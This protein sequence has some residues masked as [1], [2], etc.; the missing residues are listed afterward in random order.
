MIEELLPDGVHAAEVVGDDPT[1]YLLPEEHAAV[2]RAVER[3]RKQYTQART[4]ARRA[5][6][7]LGLPEQPILRGPK[8]EP[9]WPNGIVGSI[10]HCEGY[11][12][13]AVADR[14][15]IRSV[16]IDA[17]IHD[18]LPP[19]VQRMVAVPAEQEWLAGAGDGLHWDRVLFSAKESVYKAWFPITGAWLGFQDAELTFD[20]EGGFRARI[21]IEPPVVDGYRV[22]G[23]TGRY[24]VRDGLVL[25]S[26]VVPG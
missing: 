16:G 23:F 22:D 9:L 2:E 10:T 7:A 14:A 8:R 21:L 24:L 5:L 20:R 12:A 19:G 3:R 6:A 18:V 13:A 11:C 17:E 26:V 1:A 15:G 4:C 25:T